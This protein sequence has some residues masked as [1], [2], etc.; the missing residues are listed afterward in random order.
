MKAM[1]I[2]HNHC[3]VVDEADS[4][5]VLVNNFDTSIHIDGM[6]QLIKWMAD[7]GSQVS[8][9]VSVVVYE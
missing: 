2:V 8:L 9:T 3:T 6:E 5:H 4:Y 1:E 7:G